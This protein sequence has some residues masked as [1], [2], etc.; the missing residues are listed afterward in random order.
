MALVNVWPIWSI[1]VSLMDGLEDIYVAKK[2]EKKSMVKIVC[3]QQ[4][5]TTPKCSEKNCRS[6]T[7]LDKLPNAQI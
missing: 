3:V 1:N 4:H 5:N 2:N 7:I 6:V